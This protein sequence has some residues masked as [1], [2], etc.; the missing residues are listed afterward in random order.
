[1]RS[2]VPIVLIVLLAAGVVATA[3]E[4]ANIRQERDSAWSELAVAQRS[5]VVTT[6]QLDVA[7]GLKDAYRRS[8]ASRER[9][10]RQMQ[11]QM[12]ADR[13]RMIDCWTA[14]VR[15]VPPER[16]A[17]IFG[18]PPSYLGRPRH[19]GAFADLVRR[20]AAIVA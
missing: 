17:S 18:Q 15:I 10:I 11:H 1:M 8:V 14:L 5:L 12:N 3:Y 6:E 2:I 19:G 9:T 13:S 16:L 7:T 20:C 4:A